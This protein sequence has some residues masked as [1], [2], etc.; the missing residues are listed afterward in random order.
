MA[1]IVF[2][3]CTNMITKKRATNFEG[4]YYL[5]KFATTQS[6]LENI[7][8]GK[9]SE[10]VTLKLDKDKKATLSIGNDAMIGSWQALE[11]GDRKYAEIAFGSFSI[12]LE[13]IENY[14]ANAGYSYSY[15]L[16]YDDFKAKKT[17]GTFMRTNH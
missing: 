16:D 15:S 1:S 11:Y 17:D 13:W 14:Q 4:T 7:K 2:G 9:K 6:I 5:A 8:N 12:Y 10:P 3:S